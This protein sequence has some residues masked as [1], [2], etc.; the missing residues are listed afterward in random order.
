MKIIFGISLLFLFFS[1]CSKTSDNLEIPSWYSQNIQNNS[2]F[3]YGF[4][5]ANSLEGAKNNALVMISGSIISTVSGQIDTKKISQGEY[6]SKEVV[7]NLKVELA[8]TKFS[9]PIIE[10][11]EYK[12]KTFF[13]LVKIDKNELF[14]DI[15][16]EFSVLDSK[17]NSLNSR[18]SVVTDLE[19]IV[20]LFEI[21]EISKEAKVKFEILQSLNKTFDADRSFEK[22]SLFEQNLQKLQH[23]IDFEISTN[24][25]NF[26]SQVQK[27]LNFNKFKTTKV[28]QNKILIASNTKINETK[29][30]KIAKSNTNIQIVSGQKTINSFDIQSFGRSSTSDELATL[31]SSEDFFEKLSK[32]SQ[33][34][35]FIKK[36][37]F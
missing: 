17:I 10:K 19:K 23:E 11:Q 36:S 25:I 1:G 29:G 21:I 35:I 9:N 15:L 27:F 37:D 32:L 2:K 34:E 24:E 8:K 22:Y 31:N 12:N 28:S 30:W 33:K 3:L 4:G 14:S 20:I 6:Y 5:D 13:V 18:L 16:K 26:G 7:S